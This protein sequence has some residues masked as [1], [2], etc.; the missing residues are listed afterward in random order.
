VSQEF[1]HKIEQVIN[2]CDRAEVQDEGEYSNLF[3]EA[4]NDFKPAPTPNSKP[5]QWT[6]KRYCLCVLYIRIFLLLMKHGFDF[7]VNS[8]HL[9]YSSGCAVKSEEYSN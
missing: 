9:L 4:Q 2:Q 1:V 3:F 5:A 7:L 8:L 6:L